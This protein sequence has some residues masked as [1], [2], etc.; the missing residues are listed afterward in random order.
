MQ[1]LTVHHVLGSE[2]KEAHTEVLVHGWCPVSFGQLGDAHVR[3]PHE[4]ICGRLKEWTCW[5]APEAIRSLG[6]LICSALSKPHLLAIEIVKAPEKI[7]RAPEM[8]L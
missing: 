2:V 1:Q 4:G 5:K 8:T 3:L 6:C 7:Q